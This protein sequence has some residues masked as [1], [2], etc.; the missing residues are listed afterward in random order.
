MRGAL[1]RQNLT[2][3]SW[4][5]ALLLLILVVS[6]ALPVVGESWALQA[7]EAA[8]AGNGNDWTATAPF[9]TFIGSTVGQVGNVTGLTGETDSLFGAD[10]YT[11]QVNSNFFTCH[12]RYTD[13]LSAFC[14]EQFVYANVGPLVGVVYIQY[15]LIFY[16][17]D[18]GFCPSTGVPGGFASG[19]QSF[20]GSCYD[21]SQQTNTTAIPASRIGDI[22][23][24]A[25]ANGTKDGVVLTD[26]GSSSSWTF[27]VTDQVEGLSQ[28]WTQSEFNVFG[29]GDG[30][31][32][33]FNIGASLNVYTALRD[34]A[35]SLVSAGCA[36]TGTT[37]ETNG[38]RLGACST[39][40]SG[41][42]TFNEW[43]PAPP[44]AT[45]SCSPGLVIGKTSICMVTVPGNITA[46]GK[47][48]WSSDGVGRFSS[49]KCKLNLFG[50]CKVRYTPKSIASPVNISVR[51]AGDVNN[52]PLGGS[53]VLNV[54]Q[55]T[56]LTKI[57]CSRLSVLSGTSKTI[58]CTATVKGY[59]PSSSVT[60][61]Q[62]E[63]T[64]EISLS[65]ASCTLV[66]R[67][68]SVTLMGLLPG[69]VT[70]QAAYAGD[71][72]NTASTQVKNLTVK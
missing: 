72:N 58:K 56:S 33:N 67:S 28:H 62:V 69:P 50:F 68:C 46:T 27:G 26:R 53:S 4:M 14:W 29:F 42:M 35:G 43:G 66:K 31:Q 55:R 32:A 70:L 65:A 52:Q 15:W 48:Y 3:D 17:T 49:L 8:V 47:V 23:M 64:G 38:L 60:W 24:K 30:S 39:L 1:P 40:P 12:S 44:R 34:G 6:G 18:H 51:Y 16:Q 61:S 59:H 11:L 45:V 57:A 10:F 63:G 54:S 13:N 41:V 19:W 37:G 7:K 5:P 9:G 21:D 2:V 20:L 36:R 71:V 22:V 25:Y